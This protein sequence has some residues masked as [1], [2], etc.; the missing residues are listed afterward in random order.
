MEGGVF[1]DPIMSEGLLNGTGPSSR[2][3]A[4]LGIQ[5]RRLW[6]SSIHP[7]KAV[8]DMTWAD[9]KNP[10]NGSRLQWAQTFSKNFPTTFPFAIHDFMGDSTPSQETKKLIL[11]W[12]WLWFAG[13][14][15]PKLTL[16]AMFFICLDVF[17]EVSGRQEGAVARWFYHAWPFTGSHRDVERSETSQG[18]CKQKRCVP[19]QCCRQHQSWW[20]RDSTE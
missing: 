16:S 8:T 1:V 7:E 4:M 2:R 17:Q 14:W 18:S 20:G 9:D 12:H 5:A 19:L 13:I 3:A 11:F 10:M 6:I 15:P